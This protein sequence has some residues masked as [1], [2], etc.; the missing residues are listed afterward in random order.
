MLR[1]VVLVAALSSSSCS[2]FQ[3][4]FWSRNGGHTSFADLKGRVVVVNYWAEWCPAC[5]EEFPALAEMVQQAGPDV[6]LLPAYYTE[7]PRSKGFTRWFDAQPAWFRERVVW[8]DASVRNNEDLTGLPVTLIYGR[9][10]K[11]IE[12]FV[13][14][15]DHLG[16]EFQQAL[17]RAL[18]TTATTPDA[19]APVSA[20]GT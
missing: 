14:S 17:G 15:V 11:L 18:E 10:G 5:I 3:S 12:R 19:G 8:A 7:R 1:I 4:G 13:G 6:V 2:T 20:A 16:G 9:D